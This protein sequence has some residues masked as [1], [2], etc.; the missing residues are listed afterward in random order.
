MNV[1]A[2][3]SNSHIA[4]KNVHYA[5]VHEELDKHFS[6]YADPAIYLGSATTNPLSASTSKCCA[7]GTCN[8]FEL[9]N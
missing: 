6:Y 5:S 1:Y 3:V 2:I 9:V 7:T 8:N 4:E